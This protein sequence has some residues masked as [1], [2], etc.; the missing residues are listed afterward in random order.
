[1]LST[2]VLD[3][4]VS[5]GYE[6]SMNLVEKFHKYGL[7]FWKFIFGQL[8]SIIGDL[9]G[10]V[11]FTWWI[12]DKTKDVEAIA[13]I[14]A[15]AMFFRIFLMP[16]FGPFG[17]KFS[18]KKLLSLS[19]LWR[20]LISLVLGIMIIFD[21]YNLPVIVILFSLQSAGS[22]LY[23]S[24]SAGIIPQ[25]VNE[26][27]IESAIQISQGALS[28]GN[29]LGGIIGGSL[30]AFIGI[31]GT[32][33]LDSISFFLAAIA[34][35]SISK[36]TVPTFHHEKPKSPLKQW[37][38]EIKEGFQILYKIKILFRW[39][40]LA[41]FMNFIMAPFAIALP[42]LIKE[43]K[44]MPAWYLGW[45][46]MAGG[47]GAIAGSY[48]VAICLKFI[49]RANLIYWSILGLGLSCALLPYGE[50]LFYLM[51]FMFLFSLF[52][53]LC[54]VPASTQITIATPDQLRS[55]IFSLIGFMCQG[56]SPL[57]MA[58]IGVLMAKIGIEKTM[59][60][61]GYSLAA[62]ALISPFITH[63]FEF[64]NS[65]QEKAES[66]FETFYK[67]SK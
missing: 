25:L 17:D 21:Y 61:M 60:L 15:P 5:V 44:H 50:H 58:V 54:N 34:M 13:T 26:K 7:D 24:G 19:E 48:L 37:F 38:S 35:I 31:K 28:I 4:T 30:V 6:V 29:L 40:T 45:V 39:A 62:L 33:I 66:F 14:M 56:V 10:Y 65:S 16:L 49:S 63:F 51:I 18:R 55:R 12:L 52:G 67:I 22:A 47:V 9:C 36:N 23:Q 3:K 53:V 27:D 2:T 57:S 20:G 43:A 41:M 1:M 46:E 32:Y 42:A 11:A 64:F 59:N 8:I